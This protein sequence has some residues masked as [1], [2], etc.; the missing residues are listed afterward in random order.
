M[1]RKKSANH[2][3]FNRIGIEILF[4]LVDLYT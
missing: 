1:L 2:M 4:S 3:T